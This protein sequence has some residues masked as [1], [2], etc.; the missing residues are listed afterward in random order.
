MHAFVSYLPF[1]CFRLIGWQG[2]SRIWKL[3]LGTFSFLR[4]LALD[5]SGFLFSFH[6]WLA[7]GLLFLS[8]GL[9]WRILHSVGPPLCCLSGR[10]ASFRLFLILL[11]WYTTSGWWLGLLFSSFACGYLG[12]WVF[13]HR[14]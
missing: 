13:Y 8:I 2:E 6:F 3:E 12:M 4:N 9:L 7:S 11:V 1:L 5:S 10:L 14:H